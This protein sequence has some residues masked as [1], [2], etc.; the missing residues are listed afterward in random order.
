MLLVT[1]LHRSVLCEKG[2]RG[3]RPVSLRTFFSILEFRFNEV[4][5]NKNFQNAN[6]IDELFSDKEIQFSFK[7]LRN[8]DVCLPLIL[9]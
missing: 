3:P 1:S 2:P 7:K 8:K 4:K 9:K 5:M 6:F